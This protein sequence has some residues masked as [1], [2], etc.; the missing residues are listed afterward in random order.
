MSL[1]PSLLAINDRTALGAQ[2]RIKIV[3]TP[4][5]SEVDGIGL[6]IFTVGTHHTVGARLGAYLVA[7]GWAVFAEDEREP[8]STAADHPRRTNERRRTQPA[9]RSQP[10]HR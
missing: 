6:D 3:R 2:M 9:H 10:A 7:E 8:R 4:T 5:L 1:A